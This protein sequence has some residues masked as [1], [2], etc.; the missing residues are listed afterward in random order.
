MNSGGE[1]RQCDQRCSHGMRSQ[2]NER[3]S[4]PNG[5]KPAPR[6][7]ASVGS[8]FAAR[9]HP[10]DVSGLQPFGAGRHFEADSCAFV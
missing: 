10:L 9:L 4:G 6:T 8:G 2:Q 3:A 1:P 5:R 7:V